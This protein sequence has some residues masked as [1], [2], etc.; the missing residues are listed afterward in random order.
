[1]ASG[2]VFANNPLAHCFVQRRDYLTKC[3]DRLFVV[4]RSDGGNCLL[5]SCSHC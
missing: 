1:M 3:I 2:F 5:E 4:A